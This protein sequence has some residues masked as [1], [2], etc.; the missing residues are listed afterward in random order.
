MAPD[1]WD[2]GHAGSGTDHAEVPQEWSVSKLRSSVDALCCS[3]QSNS[4][5][6][7]RYPVA[8]ERPTITVSRAVA[9]GSDLCQQLRLAHRGHDLPERLA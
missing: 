5:G 7:W 6:K 1:L 2:G 9:T 8:A 3:S 4:L